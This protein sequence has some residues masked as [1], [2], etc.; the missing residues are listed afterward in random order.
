MRSSSW[1][2]A[3][4]VG[5]LIA[6]SWS[7]PAR[8]CSRLAVSTIQGFTTLPIDGARV[9]RSAAV[10]VSA[11]GASAL[12]VA[13]AIKDISA[14]KLLDATGRAVTLQ[15]T[16]VRVDGEVAST[17]FV[18][19]PAGLLDANAGYRVEH[20]GVVLSRFTTTNEVDRVPPPLPVAKVSQ[21]SGERVSAYGC[22]GPSQVTVTLD[23]PGDVNFLVRAEDMGTTMP[24]RALAV[25]SGATALSAVG[26]A[27]G[28]VD[29]RVMTFDL[30]GNM[31][32]APDRLI[33]FVP[34]EGVGC[35]AAPSGAFAAGL[36]LLGALRHR[37]LRRLAERRPSASAQSRR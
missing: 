16:S 24:G 34:S 35:A 7:A 13:P 19:R 4:V 10:W 6:M 23:Q 11:G 2:V 32:M 17:L 14:V 36:T 12:D 8:A 1:L 20:E 27:E 29:L 25:T 9:P 30:S 31:A 37:S 15:V 18:L 22:G 28:A 26:V 5:V 33:T 21:V 3:V